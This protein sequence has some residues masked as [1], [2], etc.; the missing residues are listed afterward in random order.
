MRE[1]VWKVGVWLARV[2]FVVGGLGFLLSLH[3]RVAGKAIREIKSLLWGFE[4]VAG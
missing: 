4:F 3:W 2:P 1:V